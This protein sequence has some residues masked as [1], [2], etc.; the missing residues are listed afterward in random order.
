M[1]SSGFYNELQKRTQKGEAVIEKLVVYRIKTALRRISN[2]TILPRS[3]SSI[4]S[5]VCITRPIH[6]P[7]APRKHHEQNQKLL[8]KHTE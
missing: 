4:I 3:S 5:L 8:S 2:P 6:I 7:L 1:V